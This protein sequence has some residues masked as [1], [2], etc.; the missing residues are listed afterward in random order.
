MDPRN[1]ERL[2]KH[3]PP[4]SMD[5]VVAWL[6]RFPVVLTITRKRTTKMGD[7]RPP[8]KYPY[9]R[10]SVNGDLHPDSFLV[11]LV[12][13]LAHLVIWEKYQRKVLPHGIQWKNQF[14]QMLAGFTGK[15]IFSPEI[16]NVVSEF[17]VGRS[18]YRMFNLVFE[19]KI[20]EIHPGDHV[21]LLG[22]I[23]VNST[24]SLQNGRTFI[25][26]E[27]LRTRFRCMEVKTGRYF[28]VSPLAKVNLDHDAG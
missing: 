21:S 5:P 14:R 15:E 23:P 7:Y 2:L 16:E 13:E 3:L 17:A 26:K 4:Q 20:H 24:F 12:H 25:K 9:H 1:R 10:I 27:K 19:K 11:T 18:S 22:E 28:L 6:D 8:Q